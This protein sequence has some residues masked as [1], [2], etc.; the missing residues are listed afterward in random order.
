MIYLAFYRGRKTIRSPIDVVY[1]LFDW[2]V[3]V[4]TWSEFSH[5]EIAVKDEYGYTCYSASG[6]DKGVRS[7]RIELNSDEW[8]LVDISHIVNRQ[9]IESYYQHTDQAKYDYAG[10]IGTVLP[11]IN[12][13]RRFFCSEWVWN[14]IQFSKIKP[15]QVKKS[16]HRFSPGDLFEI[17]N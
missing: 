3:R 4:I 17:F 9:A 14:A 12:C 7:K 2:L 15:S 5:C 10:C 8:V 6:R 16:G 13:K 11:A 1:R